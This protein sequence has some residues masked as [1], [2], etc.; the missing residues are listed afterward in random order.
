MDLRN[1]NA[2]FFAFA[3]VFAVVAFA[4][5]VHAAPNPP[6]YLDTLSSSSRQLPSTSNGTISAQGGNITQVN[7]EAITI[8][9]SWQGYY[10][11]ITGNIVLE[12]GNNNS[13]YS[14][15]NSSSMAGEVYAT[16]N[17]TIQ[18]QNIRCLNGAERTAEET[19]LGQ[20]AGSGD[21][22]TNTFNKTAH[23][24]FYVGT[25]PI[26]NNTCFST[27]VNVN[28]STQNDSFYQLLL[29]DDANNSVY[30][31]II[32]NKKNAFNGQI[33]DFQLMVGENEHT[34]NEGPTSY[35]FFVELS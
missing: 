11:N 34:G 24:S 13:F 4:Q 22:I 9:K 21:S 19:Y 31:T 29:S 35:Y 17:S 5:T 30:T 33:A 26:G 14:W 1:S 7:I 20:F 23:P 8:T 18:W 32:E 2:I 16:R 10:G 28:G 6:V 25:V 15:G 12:D 27:N 3:V